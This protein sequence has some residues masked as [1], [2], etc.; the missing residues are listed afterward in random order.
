LSKIFAKF[1]D[2]F[3][4]NS[5]EF[6]FMPGTENAPRSKASVYAQAV[7]TFSFPAS[8]IPCLLGAM[9]AFLINPAASAWWLMPFIVVSLILLHSA[10]NVISDFDD[11]RLGVD[12][13]ETLGGSRVLVDDLIKPKEMFRFGVTLF[14]LAVLIGIPIIYAR[15]LSILLFGLIGIIG[16]FFYTGRPIGYKYI[17]L[18][19]FFIFIIY[20]PAI[21][22]G[23]FY[24]LTGTFSPV[25]VYTS[26][27][28]GLLIAGILQANNLR[29]ISHDKNANIKTL[30]TIFGEG[31]AKA[32]YLFL[33]IGAYVTVIILVATRI[34]T[35]WSLLVLLSLPPAIKNMNSIRGITVDDTAK[36]AML[37]A[38]TAQLT[39]MFGVLLSIS[40]LI[41]KFV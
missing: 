15:G 27:P 30:A 23:T 25:A 1:E 33:I 12:G 16:G 6:V 36:I 38:Q 22:S 35:P 37:D 4:I 21:V 3:L 18:G 5:K 39:L 41:S 13:K 2:I 7:R 28:L 8:M 11:Y 26:I 20:G 31:F 24:A 29:D 14:A 17:A 9:L 10:S 19:D 32:E 34:L 40:V